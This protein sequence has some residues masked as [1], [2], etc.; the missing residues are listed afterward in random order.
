MFESRTFS[1]SATCPI[2]GSIGA[3]SRLLDKK[4]RLVVNL[5]DG[6]RAT[7][8]DAEVWLDELA[9]SKE[10]IPSKD[11]FSFPSEA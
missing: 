9:E 7:R 6:C 10:S 5:R 1:C 11:T 2:R 8:S 4:V 3:R